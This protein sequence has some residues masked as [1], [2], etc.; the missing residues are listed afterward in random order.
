M[1]K[2]RAPK[3]TTDVKTG[4]VIVFKPGTRAGQLA[5]LL[6][7]LRASGLV[8]TVQVFTEITQ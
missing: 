5:P 8:A 1:G 2:K 4:M 7:A 3:P 6:E